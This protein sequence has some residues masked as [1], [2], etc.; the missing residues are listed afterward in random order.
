VGS[1]KDFFA[2]AVGGGFARR[3]HLFRFVKILHPRFG[4]KGY[5]EI[6]R[7]R[8]RIAQAFH[9]LAVGGKLAR[10]MNRDDR[11]QHQR[12]DQSVALRHLRRAHEHQ[13]DAGLTL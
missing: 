6:R 2:L 4:K 7:V 1:G 8:G 3:R 11:N 9:L 12:G 5:R 13:A 10:E